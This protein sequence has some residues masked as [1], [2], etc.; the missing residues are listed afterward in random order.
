MPLY[1]KPIGLGKEPE[2][3]KA[4]K[5]KTPP[6]STGEYGPIPLG[7]VAEDSSGTTNTSSF[8]H[9]EDSNLSTK[10]DNSLTGFGYSVNF[11]DGAAA[12]GY[13]NSGTTDPQTSNYQR[14]TKRGTEDVKPPGETAA[15]GAGPGGL[16]DDLQHAL[17]I[18]YSGA[19]PKPSTIPFPPPGMAMTGEHMGM[20]MPPP[21]PAQSYEFQPTG[22]QYMGYEPYQNS[23]EGYVAASEYEGPP[24]VA[25]MSSGENGASVMMAAENETEMYTE[26]MDM[27]MMNSAAYEQEPAAPGDDD[28]DDLRMLGIDVDDTSVVHLK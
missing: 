1:K 22:Y 7:K 9:T 6:A 20:G 26:A 15:A 14:S 10:S 19:G 23:F 2:S 5:M 17:D 3:G 25:E 16:P 11:D 28:I 13:D 4:T 18:I 24:G 8:G 12:A 27:N 21:P